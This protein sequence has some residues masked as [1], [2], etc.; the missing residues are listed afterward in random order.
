M[1]VFS[2]VGR[3]AKMYGK[4]LNINAARSVVNATR[5]VYGLGVRGVGLGMRGLD[6]PLIGAAKTLGRG[7]RSYF[8]GGASVAQRGARI[9]TAVGGGLLGA[10][11]LNPK[12]NWGPF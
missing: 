1:S 5:N 6:S 12:D 11:F 2:S 4:L 10:N 7:S 8:W 9:G 3:Y